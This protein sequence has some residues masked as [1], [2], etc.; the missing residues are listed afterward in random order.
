MSS[1]TS[2]FRGNAL[3]ERQPFDRTGL[4]SESECNNAINADIEA[5]FL[6]V[7]VQPE[8]CK[9]LRLLWRDNT[10]DP[11][12]VCEYGRPFFGSKSSPTCANYALQQVAKDNAQKSHQIDKLITR[13]QDTGQIRVVIGKCRVASIQTNKP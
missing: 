3:N 8:D 6:Q 1:A 9:V 10:S 13:K 11:V 4:T 7:K 2:K 12:K 5:K